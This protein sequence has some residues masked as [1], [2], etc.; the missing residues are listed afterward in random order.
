MPRANKGM[1]SLANDPVSKNTL[2]YEGTLIQC[3]SS[4][5]AIIVKINAEHQNDIIIEDIDD[6]HVLIK[7]EKHP[8]LKRLLDD[9]SPDENR[10]PVH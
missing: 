4:I 5:K 7:T 2:T 6:E 9:V 3:D 10:C 8:Q 1:A